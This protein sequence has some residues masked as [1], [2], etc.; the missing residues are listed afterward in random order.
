MDWINIAVIF[1]IFVLANPFASVPL[2][3]SAHRHKF[4]VKKVSIYAVFIAFLVAVLINFIGPS[5]FRAFGITLDSFRIAG[6]IILLFLAMQTIFQSETE[7]VQKGFHKV[8]SLISIIATPMLT[9]PATMSFIT[10]KSFELGSWAL[11]PN[12]ILSFILVGIVFFAFALAVSKV[13]IKFI[14]ISS[15]IFGLFLTAMAVELIVDGIK[16]AF[17]F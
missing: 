17:L 8:D 3:F 1:Q 13:N 15:K 10:V 2:I 11:F 12:I 4:N 9:G 16:G 7:E 6:G 14:N 5:L